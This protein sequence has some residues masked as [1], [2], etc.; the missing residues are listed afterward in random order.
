MN[1]VIISAI[2]LISA[3]EYRLVVKLNWFV[4]Y[5]TEQSIEIDRLKAWCSYH[6]KTFQIII[7]TAKITKNSSFK[8]GFIHFID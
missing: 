2:S 5:I 4:C 7:I 1:I 6:F 8:V 3:T